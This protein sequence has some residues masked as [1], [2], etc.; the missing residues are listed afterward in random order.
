MISMKIKGGRIK[1]NL[2]QPV[3]NM[4]EGQRKV[5]V[6]T[7]GCASMWVIIS[8]FWWRSSGLNIWSPWIQIEMIE[9]IQIQI[10]AYSSLTLPLC[11]NRFICPRKL[12]IAF[13]SMVLMYFRSHFC[14]KSLKQQPKT[15]LKCSDQPIQS[16]TLA[17]MECSPSSS[18]SLS[19]INV[20]SRPLAE[21]TCDVKREMTRWESTNRGGGLSEQFSSCQLPIKYTNKWPINPLGGEA[22]CNPFCCNK[23]LL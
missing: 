14:R 11:L 7:A 21:C 13:N 1:C 16:F 8:S 17:Q 10:T 3:S 20:S 9:Q 15:Q 22:T 2:A 19:D 23:A 6:Q 5:S 4:K 12:H 18:P